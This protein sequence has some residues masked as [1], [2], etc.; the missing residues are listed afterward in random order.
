MNKMNCIIKEREIE[1][2]ITKERQVM[3]ILYSEAYFSLTNLDHPFA[4]CCNFTFT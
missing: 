2:A 4:K 1:S 3:L